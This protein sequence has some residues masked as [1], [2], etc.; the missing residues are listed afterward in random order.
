MTSSGAWTRVIGESRPDVI[1]HLAGS[2]GRGGTERERAAA[3]SRGQIG[4]L[5]EL[6]DQ[7]ASAVRLLEPV[8]RGHV[9]VL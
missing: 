2:T 6:H 9:G 8:D 1:F 4:A 3:D 5:D 7:E